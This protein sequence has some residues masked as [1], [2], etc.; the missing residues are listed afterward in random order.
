MD[1]IA[2][3]GAGQAGASAAE[4]L[5]K[6]GYSG[7][8]TLWGDEPHIPYQR[9][10]LSKAY[11]LGEM[12][13]ERLH[14]RPRAFW[15]EHD[16]E[17]R[18]DTSVTALD[19]AAM[20]LTHDGGTEGFDAAILAT[21]STARR[22]PDAMG[23]SLPGVF[24]VR[25]LSDIDAMEPVFR[26]GAHLLVVGGGYIGLEAAAV[27]RKRGMRVTLLEAAERI[28]ARVACAET[29][30]WFRDRHRAEGVEIRE[31]AKLL[32]LLGDTHVTGAELDGGEV[33]E[34]DAVVC[35]IGIAPNTAL[36]AAAGLALDD[37][38]AVDASGQTS[39]PGIWAAGDCCSFPWK[40]GRLRLESVPHAI[41][42]AETVARN[43]LGG[44]ED[45]VAKPWF[46]SDQY[47]VKLQIAGLNRG[48]DRVVTRDAPDGLS[49]WYYTGDR[50]VAV[51]AISDARAYM[52]GKRLIEAGSSPDPAR[53]ADA[54]L[55]VK[56]LLTR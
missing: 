1:H 46:W 14:L 13:R 4:T 43:V 2:I 55:P 54:A 36:A 3:I 29:A 12:A 26:E 42:Q 15:E 52:V 11:L 30:A 34:I 25:T 8:L 23:G 51:D 21:G 47:D 9:P 28:L 33:L 31:T 44:T 40:D 16:V 49:H 45:Y 48:H 22:L 18:L 5:R 37:G 24:G 7:R 17:L 56:E 27:A 38:I 6:Q 10:P 50:L 39:A 32:R 20:T 19:P 35:G 41:H 53:V